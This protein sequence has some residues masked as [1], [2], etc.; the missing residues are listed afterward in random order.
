M[1]VEPDE[2]SQAI[3][4]AKSYLKKMKMGIPKIWV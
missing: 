1:R 2:L 4:H 3:V